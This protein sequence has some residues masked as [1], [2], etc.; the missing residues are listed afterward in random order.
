VAVLAVALAAGL[1]MLLLANLGNRAP[2]VTF[3][4]AVILAALYG[5]LVPGLLATALS[6]A[7]ADFFWMEPVGSFAIRD[8]GDWLSLGVFLLSGAMISWTAEAMRR[9]RGRAEAAEA[10]ARLDTERR[11]ADEALR[12][13][14]GRLNLYIDHSPLAVIEWDGDLRIL[15]WAGEAQRVFGWTAEE[16]LGRRIDEFPVIYPED[17]DSVDRVVADLLSGSQRSIVHKNRN[18]RKDGAVIYCEWYNTPTRDSSGRLVSMLSQVLDVTASNRLM[19]ELSRYELLSENIRDI[20]LYIRRDSGRI[21]EA[22]AAAASAYGYT[23]QE[24]AELSVQD[25]RAP[26]TAEYAATQM[27]IADSHSLLFETIH[28]RGDGSTFPVEVSS[29]GATIEGTRMLISVVRDITERRK[30]EAALRESEERLRLFIQYAPAAVAMFDRDMRYLAVSRRWMADYRLEDREFAGRSHY[31]LFPEIPERWREI[32]RRCLDGAVER[33]EEDPFPRADGTLTWLRWEI[34]PW[35]N[36]QGE[37]GGIVIFT[38]DITGRK[39]AE[40]AVRQ[41]REWLRVT[42]ASIGD[43]VLATDTEGRITLLNLAAAALTGWTEPEAVGKPARDVLRIVNELTGE[44][45]D[46]VGRILREGRPVLLGNHK[47]LLDREGRTIPVEDSAAP[48]KD[49]AGGLA[50]AVLVFHDVS[51]RR[52]AEEALRQASEQRRVA[53]E[54]AEM[55]SWDYRFDSGQIMLD[56]RCLKTVGLAAGPAGYRAIDMRIHPQDRTAVRQALQQALA[57]AEEGAFHREFRLLWPDGSLHW[58]SAHGRVLFEGEGP[59]RRPLRFVGVSMDITDRKKAE[60]RLRESQ[61]L[62]SIAVLAGGIAH[63]FNNLLVGVIGN[64]TLAQEMLPP[65]DPTGKLVEEIVR[66]GQHAAHLTRQMLAYSGRGRL[67]AEPLNLSDLVLETSG[68]VRPSIPKKVV[69]QF[70]LQPNV[71]LILA[72]R[73][74]IQQ[75]FTNLVLNAAEAIGSEAGS[76]SVE[77]GVRDVDEAYISLLPEL[78]DLRPGRHVFL[79]VRD[80]GCGIDDAAK[81]RIFEPFF[82]TKFTGR[83]LGLAAV[84]GIVR[85]HKGAIQVSSEPGQGTSFVVLFPAME[86]AA[87][88]PGSQPPAG[89]LRGSGT[90]LVVDDEETV[91]RMAMVSLERYGYR[92]LEATTGLA[93]IDVFKR[94]PGEIS[95]VLLDLTMPEMGGEEALRE[96]RKIRPDV[97]VVISSGYGESEALKSFQGRGFAG[98]IQK[99]YT[100]AQLAEQIARALAS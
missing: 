54:A 71:P 44:P 12:E 5:G 61:K 56:E 3:F 47:A 58:V 89:A 81:A 70:Q 1:R 66:A 67:V 27:E 99:P 8:P 94:Y 14:H 24:L 80:T 65:G 93:A 13:A 49:A 26:D 2:Y 33:S 68:V 96:L 41:H 85:A 20:V 42:L 97:K 51:Q 38:E 59:Q 77:T 55:G 10:Q 95:A 39:L 46:I 15:R 100:P 84:A 86:R 28:R 82:T 92:V 48:I 7:L 43:A 31:E 4:P 22:N 73:G 57:G 53:L 64:A 17:K 16:V 83:G 37:I 87:P 75:I 25:L 21:V 23:R 45:D 76:I 62:E 6:A 35:R 79:A 60:A 72:D 50:G 9:A 11:R 29:Q 32:H 69:L 90:I 63:D 18:V 52:R 78:T 91:R 98:F 19:R 36:A 34:H 74:Q 30:M 40:E 88:A